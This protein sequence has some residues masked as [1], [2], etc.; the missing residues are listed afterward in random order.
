MRP[1]VSAKNLDRI[2]SLELSLESAKQAYNEIVP[3][4]V[5]YYFET[6]GYKFSHMGRPKPNEIYLCPSKWEP[7]D[8]ETYDLHKVISLFDDSTLYT[9]VFKSRSAF[10]VRDERIY[11][12]SHNKS[13]Q[14]DG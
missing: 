5:D 1:F 3:R 11:K 13:I 4:L 10:F 2:E 7:G 6:K 9:L 12:K 8:D 14:T